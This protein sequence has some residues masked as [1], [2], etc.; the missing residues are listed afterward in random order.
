MILKTEKK[1]KIHKT[2][3]N[4]I[5]NNQCCLF[6]GQAIDVFPLQGDGGLSED[7]VLAVLVGSRDG[8]DD[9]VAAQ[10]SAVQP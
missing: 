4:C 5:W 7:A 10:H 6:F 2:N 9:L 3:L 8:R 1:I